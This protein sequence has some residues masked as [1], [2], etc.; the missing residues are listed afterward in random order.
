MKKISLLII[1]IFTIFLLN[2]CTS[3]AQT[4][5]IDSNS[6]DIS[7]LLKTLIQK[8]KEINELNKKLELCKEQKTKK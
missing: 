5:V 6:K 4:D 3:K 1:S 8:E 2:G 7:E